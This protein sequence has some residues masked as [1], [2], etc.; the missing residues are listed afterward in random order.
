VLSLI[1]ALVLLEGE[2]V[3]LLYYV[4][5]AA[6]LT[7]LAFFVKK[8]LYLSLISKEQQAETDAEAPRG[9]WKNL[10]MAFV[11][12]VLS[13]TFPLLLA[14]FLPPAAWFIVIV[15]FTTAMGASEII[16]YMQ[17]KPH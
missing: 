3:L 13:L 11:I 7:I 5:A 9:S 16:I 10:L 8:R 2:A 12:M 14:G 6:V 1:L 4:A 17:S 15:S